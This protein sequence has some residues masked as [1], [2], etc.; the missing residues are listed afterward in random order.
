MVPPEATL[1][2]TWGS[3]VLHAGFG[4]LAMIRHYV[5]R[6]GTLLSAELRILSTLKAKSATISDKSP[7]VIL[8][9]ILVERSDRRIAVAL[10]CIHLNTKRPQSA[11]VITRLTYTSAIFLSRMGT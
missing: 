4:A 7:T 9:C 2:F 8:I 6:D 3:F 5:T 1:G 11:T 10:Y